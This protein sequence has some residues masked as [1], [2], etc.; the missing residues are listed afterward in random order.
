M[1]SRAAAA[2]RVLRQEIAR[3]PT[4]GDPYAER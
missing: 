2:E 3:V 4:A 1:V